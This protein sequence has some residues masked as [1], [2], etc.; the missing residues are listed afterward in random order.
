MLET[1]QMYPSEILRILWKNFGST[2]SV[3]MIT[4][5]WWHS[6][7]SFT[8]F[9]RRR[10]LD[11]SSGV[12]DIGELRWELAGTLLLVWIMCY[13]CI[14]KGVKWTGKVVYFTALFP[15][16]LLSVLLVRGITLPGAFVGI[17]F[18]LNPNMSKLGDSQ[19][20]VDAVT[21]IFF[22]Y[23]LGLGTLIALGSYNKYSNNVYKWV[24]AFYFLYASRLR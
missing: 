7:K 21:Q 19:V 5:T 2:I 3:Q 6:Y 24:V 11:I 14:W 10:V 17:K 18:Y 20:W 1:G 16:F 15:Y 22:S 13:F 4:T 23:G 8:S 12:E 9:L